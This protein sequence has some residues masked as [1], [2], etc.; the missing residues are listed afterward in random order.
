VETQRNENHIIKVCRARQD[1][2]ITTIDLARALRADDFGDPGTPLTG[3]AETM[4]STTAAA[5]RPPAAPVCRSAQPWTG[6]QATEIEASEIGPG[7]YKNNYF[8]LTFHFP[9]EWQV[10]DRAQ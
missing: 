5:P 3:P 9:A 8:G 7:L 4:V 6:A 10:A 1:D 2:G